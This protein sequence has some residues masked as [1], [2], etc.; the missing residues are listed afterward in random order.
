MCE[1]HNQPMELVCKE[2]VK[3]ICIN[4]K[5]IGHHSVSVVI[6]PPLEWAVEQA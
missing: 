2:C 3:Q 1:T 4:C 6:L 5:L